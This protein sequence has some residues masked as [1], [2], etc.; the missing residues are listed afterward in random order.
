MK[1]NLKKFTKGTIFYIIIGYLFCSY[2]A[3]SFSMHNW[4]EWHIA[5]FVTFVVTCAA[6][7]ASR[8][9]EKYL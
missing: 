8:I 4:K 2:L 6:F 5:V 3:H 9:Y 1:E 7:T